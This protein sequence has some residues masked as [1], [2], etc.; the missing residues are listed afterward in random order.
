MQSFATL[1]STASDVSHSAA[2][3]SVAACAQVLTCAGSVAAGTSASIEVFTAD[4]LIPSPGIQASFTYKLADRQQ[5]PFELWCWF[6]PS[7]GTDHQTA[8]PGAEVSNRQE[9][10]D[11]PPDRFDLL[12]VHF[13][14]AWKSNQQ[15]CCSMHGQYS[16]P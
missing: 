16:V 10:H 8:Q 15:S 2:C 4:L 1:Y 6:E 12:C 13:D 7:N 9:G 5:S 14:A 3:T 11:D